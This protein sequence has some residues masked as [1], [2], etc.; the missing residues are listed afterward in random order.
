MNRIIKY[1]TVT[2]ITIVTSVYTFG[3]ISAVGTAIQG[4][5]NG[6][7]QNEF[8]F[9]VKTHVGEG[10][11]M[12]DGTTDEFAVYFSTDKLKSIAVGCCDIQLINEGDLNG[13]GK[14][15][16][17]VFQAPI[18]GCSYSMTTYSYTN[19]AWNTFIETFLIPTGCDGLN[20]KELQKRVFSENGNVYFYDVDYN[21]ENFTLIKKK[22]KISSTK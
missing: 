12:E 16:I 6:D 20:D 5:F 13:D 3:Q 2:V 18:N 1:L 22:V 21:D 9:S 19:N 11:P 8:A 10:N 14:D 7:G 4:D 17:S 15:E